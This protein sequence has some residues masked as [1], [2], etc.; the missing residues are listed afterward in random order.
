MSNWYPPAS[1]PRKVAGGLRAKSARG[2]IAQTWWSQRFIAVLE[3]FGMG[4]RLQRGRSYARQG[5]VLSLTV[6]AGTV[7]ATVQ[8]SRAKPYRVRIGV[9]AFGKDQWRDV[10]QALV[11]SAWYLARLLGDQMP[12]DIEEVFAAVGL[13]LFPQSVR[14]ISMDCTCPDIAVPCK[15]VAATFYLLAECFDADPFAILA[16]R[17]RDRQQ[18]L[19]T[20][21]AAG[22][23]PG[24]ADVPVADPATFYAMPARV[25]H[26]APPGAAAAA[27]LDELPAVPVA[28]RGHDLTELLR[29]AYAALGR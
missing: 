9:T 20:L 12:E 29:P 23:I 22:P 5:Q 15:H 3:G 16:W 14:E 2:A 7:S 10:E 17:G 6:D 8:G 28:I 27:L 11:A 24:T 21:R 4:N 18:L 13:S 26:L 25:R 1:K 19:A